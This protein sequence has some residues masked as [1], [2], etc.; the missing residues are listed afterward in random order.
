MIGA[1]AGVSHKR[2]AETEESVGDADPP[3]ALGQ[4]DA[5]QAERDHAQGDHHIP[6]G[7]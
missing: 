5:G 1:Q 3:L 2:Y 4:E 7:G 6:H